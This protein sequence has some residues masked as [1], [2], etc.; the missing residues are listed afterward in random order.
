MTVMF[1]AAL[2]AAAVGLALPA[3]A[4]TRPAFCPEGRTFSGDCVEPDAVAEARKD[5]LMATQLKLSMTAPQIMPG[6]AD[7]GRYRYNTAETRAFF[8]APLVPPVVIR[9]C[10]VACLVP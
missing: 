1:R 8:V 4:Q 9:G 7:A 2:I 5:A 3:M 10:V 6:D